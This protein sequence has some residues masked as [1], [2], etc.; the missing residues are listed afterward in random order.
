MFWVIVAPLFI[1]MVLNYAGII[2]ILFIVVLL[3]MFF[4][5]GIGVFL[6]WVFGHRDEEEKENPDDWFI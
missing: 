3:C 1:I 5:H 2:G 4:I 6:N